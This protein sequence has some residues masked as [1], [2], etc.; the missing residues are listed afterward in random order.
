MQP[1]QFRAGWVDRVLTAMPVV[2]WLIPI[3]LTINGGGSAEWLVVHLMVFVLVTMWMLQTWRWRVTVDEEGITVQP[4][5]GRTRS[6]T[7][8]DIE[9]VRAERPRA[10]LL[11][12]DG[13]VRL[14]GLRG[15]P[16]SESQVREVQRVV[17]ER[18]SG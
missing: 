7:W 4:D 15:T 17:A 3:T 14:G 1:R 6:V 16:V 13:E 9:D 5:L 11:R 12:D 8:D 10:L 18:H 2:G